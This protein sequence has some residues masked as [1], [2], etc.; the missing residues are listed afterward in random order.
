MTVTL[1]KQYEKW[2]V[3]KISMPKDTNTPLVAAY[4]K[5]FKGKPSQ[6]LSKANRVNG[7]HYNL[8]RFQEWEKGRRKLPHVIKKHMQRAVLVSRFGPQG[9]QLLK[10]LDI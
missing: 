6:A 2:L 3:K 4:L 1:Q 5:L 10:L 9:H 7:S 8:R